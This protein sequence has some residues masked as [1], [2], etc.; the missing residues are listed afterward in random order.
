MWVRVR[1][2]VMAIYYPNRLS[3]LQLLRKALKQIHKSTSEYVQDQ[4]CE[5]SVR[6]DKRGD[7]NVLDRP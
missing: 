4:Q 6:E 1:E 7:R 3:I 5:D 2:P